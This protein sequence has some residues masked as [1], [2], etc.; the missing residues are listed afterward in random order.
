MKVYLGKLRCD[1]VD[2]F[3]WQATFDVIGSMK[4]CNNVLRTVQLF[5][6]SI[7][8]YITKH[9]WTSWYFFTFK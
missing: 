3:N 1:A 5:S 6:I 9:N 2:I 4:I 8:M 7:Q